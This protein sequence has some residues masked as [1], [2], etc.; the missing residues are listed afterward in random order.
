MGF[1]SIN[2]DDIL[3]I[4]KY[5]MNRNNIKKNVWVYEKIFIGLLSFSGSLA[6]KCM[7]LNNGQF[8]TRAFLVDLNPIELKYYPCIIP[9]DKCNPNCNT[10][11]E[12]SGRICTPNKTEDVNLNVF[13]LIIR[14]NE[15]KTI[16]KH[17]SCKYNC[18]SGGKKCN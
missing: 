2:V 12:I 9:L 17:I 10:L 8:K 7:S 15:Q 18:K 5:L 13:N 11:G 16:I 14:T 6:T 4:H 3:D 1:G